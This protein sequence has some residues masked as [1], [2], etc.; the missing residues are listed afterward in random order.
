MRARM[1]RGISV[2]FGSLIDDIQSLAGEMPFSVFPG[3]RAIGTSA[4]TSLDGSTAPVAG[5]KN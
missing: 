4:K 2:G 5:R 1:Q 3:E